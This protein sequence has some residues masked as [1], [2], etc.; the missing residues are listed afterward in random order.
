MPLLDTKGQ[1]DGRYSPVLSSEA[2]GW[3]VIPCGIPSPVPEADR[4]LDGDDVRGC[5]GV[6]SQPPLVAHR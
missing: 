3:C 2:H 4:L 5:G 1:G 6:A